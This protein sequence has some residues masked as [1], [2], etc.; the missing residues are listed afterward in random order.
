MYRHLLREK[1][2]TVDDIP[3]LPALATKIINGCFDDRTDY[4]SLAALV[5]QD[6][7]LSGKVLSLINA[8]AYSP[9]ER[10]DDLGHAISLLGK[11]T[12][13]NLV[14]SISIYNSF[15]PEGKK[16]EAR[17]VGFWQHSLACAVAAEAIARKIGYPYPEEA[18]LGG[19]LH[20]IGKLIIFIRFPDELEI[21][22]DHLQQQHQSTSPDMQPLMLED[23]IFGLGHHQLGKWAAERWQFPE[24]IVNS[25]WLHHQPITSFAKKEDQLP[26]MIR[27]ADAFCNIHHLGSNYFINQD[28]DLP[29]HPHHIQS[30]T[31]LQKFF[32][33]KDEEIA[34]LL[35]ETMDRMGEFSDTLGLA[36]NQ[37]YFEAIKKAN[38]ELGRMNLAREQLAH[39]LRLKNRILKGIYRLEQEI[40][41]FHTPAELTRII[42]QETI[43]TFKSDLA[44]CFL[45]AEDSQPAGLGYAN[46]KF[47]NPQDWLAQDNSH[48]SKN[49]L[50]K[51]QKKSLDSIEKLLLAPDLFLASEKII[52]LLPHSTLLAIPLSYRSGNSKG[53][54]GQLIIDCR[55]I[56]HYGGEKESLLQI[57][58]IFASAV[59]N[60]V[61]KVMLFDNLNQQ[62]EELAELHRHTEQIQE[63]LYH[64][65]R[66]AT[67]GRLAAGAAHEIN[68]PLAV[69]S[70][71]IQVMQKQDPKS[72]DRKK[73]LSHYQTVLQQTEKISKI[74]SDMMTYAYPAK[75]QRLTANLQEIIAQAISA[76]EH[77]TSYEKITINNLVPD[78]LP[79]VNVDA[80]QIGQ[81]LINLLIN[82]QQAIPDG[83][84]ITLKGQQQEDHVVV[85]C[86]DT[87][88][89][90]P[91]EQQSIIFDPFFTTREAG[92]GTG[93]G[94]AICH[95]LMEQ[96]N[97]KITVRS[98]VGTGTTFTLLLPIARQTTSNPI[99]EALHHDTENNRA[100][101]WKPDRARILLVE[102]DP[103]LGNILAENLSAGFEVEVVTSDKEAVDIVRQKLFNLLIIDLDVG[104]NPA[105]NI[106]RWTAKFFNDLP[107]IALT[108]PDAAAQQEK[109]KNLGITVWHQ[110]PFKTDELVATATM[111]LTQP[112]AG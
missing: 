97:G 22:L 109:L 28:V 86:S 1:I 36:D 99:S 20:D 59:A 111:L 110:K 53:T 69:I 8:S 30:F 31:V 25:I 45:K 51:N 12:I 21:F 40:S 63:Q 9:V 85:E 39:E 105:K 101:N 95:S 33:W 93:L 68:N 62:S 37:S 7:A 15:T 96:N 38:R 23:K 83:G 32:K 72:R 43:E 50:P 42:L 88:T 27:F 58:H 2:G 103:E 77:R 57:L 112:T 79:L 48:N 61:H 55:K 94:L 6:L 29:C 44:L 108:G 78:D 26:V 64:T 5:R 82:A 84:T 10:I 80:M 92:E 49:H 19:L 73:E 98:K 87:G 66:L 74:I 35:S 106:L 67:V 65:Q 89:G 24:T 47:F 71:N 3:P 16:G 46:K 13:R 56:I 70:A 81:V 18:F 34:D 90:I 11:K 91:P 14:L 41:Q 60:N 102:N 54:I 4:K 76:V 52:P 75:P 100:V 107:I 104:G 17:M